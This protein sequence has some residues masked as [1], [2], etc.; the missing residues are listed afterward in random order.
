MIV[1]QK[2]AFKKVY[3]KLHKNQLTPVNKAIQTI[4]DKPE[5]G[6]EKRETW[7]VF[8]ST[9]LTVLTNNT[10][11]PMNGMRILEPCYCW[12]CMKTFIGI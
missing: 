10:Y 5:L 12:V 6:T 3:K 1:S 7:Q 11:S 4:I 2:P 9:N 8:M